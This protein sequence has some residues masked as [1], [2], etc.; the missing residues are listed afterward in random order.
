MGKLYDDSIF[1]RQKAVEKPAAARKPLFALAL[2]LAVVV[3]AAIA[4]W[5]WWSA[6]QPININTATVEQL[7]S[8]PEVGP[9][10]AKK[11]VAGRPY[12]TPEDLKR[13]PG[14]GDKTFEKMKTRVRVE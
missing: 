8:I 6:R 1:G 11:I 3:L 14:I 5:R 2:V 10:I 4:G 13:V 12:T 7:E 9:A